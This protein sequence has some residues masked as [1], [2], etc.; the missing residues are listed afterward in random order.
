ME[1]Y[2]DACDRDKQQCSECFTTCPKADQCEYKSN[3]NTPDDVGTH[4]DFDKLKRHCCVV[5]V[6]CRSR[7]DASR[8]EDG[9]EEKETQEYLEDN[10]KDFHGES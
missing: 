10:M 4:H 9:H 6:F 8:S 3:A 5:H 2:D 1:T 7:E